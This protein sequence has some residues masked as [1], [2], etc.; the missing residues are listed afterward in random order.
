MS[1]LKKL[2]VLGVV[3]FLATPM[4][5]ASEGS[6]SGVV[7]ETSCGKKTN[8]VSEQ[9]S[10]MTAEEYDAYLRDLNDLLCHDGGRPNTRPGRH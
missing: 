7:V 9:G 2:F 3:A 6:S 4:L 10:G 5:Q 8:T 1:N